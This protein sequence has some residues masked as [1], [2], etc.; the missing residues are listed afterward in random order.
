MAIITK[1]LSS[2]K[3][4]KTLTGQSL[5][6]LGFLQIYR[7]KRAQ[8]Q[9]FYGYIFSEQLFG[10]NI[11]AV[12]INLKKPQSRKWSTCQ[13]FKKFTLVNKVSEI[14]GEYK[15]QIWIQ[16]I[17]FRVGV[18]HQRFH[19]KSKSESTTSFSPSVCPFWYCMHLG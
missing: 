3:Y 19:K 13:S 6:A 5:S 9:K 15:K 18:K 10:E 7:N 4:F 1:F 11:S 14:M 16:S 17:W 8:Q 2:S 12:A